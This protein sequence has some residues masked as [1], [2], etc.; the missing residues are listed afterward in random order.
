VVVGDQ[1]PRYRLADAV[2]V[3][4]HRGQRQDPL[5]HAHHHACRGVPAVA[6]EIEL[7]F[8]GLVDRLDDL[9]QGLEQLGAGPGLLIPAGG[10]QQAHT[11][12]GQP[13]LEQA[14]VIVLEQAAV[15]VLVSDEQ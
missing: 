8:E 11:Q 5:E 3:P 4:D 1:R 13:G 7:A 10:A 6:F 12:V 14:A 9:P 15:I 2:V